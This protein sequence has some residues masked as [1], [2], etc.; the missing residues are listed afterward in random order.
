MYRF[1]LSF[2]S[3]YF[4]LIWLYGLYGHKDLTLNGYSSY[5]K[6]VLRLL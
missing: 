2:F 5:R 4:S 1:N 6:Y 3:F